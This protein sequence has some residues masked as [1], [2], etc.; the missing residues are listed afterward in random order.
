MAHG[1]FHRQRLAPMSVALVTGAARG[2][3]AATVR[4][5]GERGWSIVAF[6]RAEDDPALPYPLGT[7][8]Q[9]HAPTAPNVHVVAGD[10]RDDRAL[11]SAVAEAE[12][13]F[14]G[15]DAAIAIAGVIAGGL[16]LWQLPR[17]QERAVIDVNLGGVLAL[18]PAAI[19]VLLRRPAARSGRFLAVASA[20]ATSGLPMLAAY[21]ASKAA[22]TG[23]IRA[24]AVELGDSGVTAVAVSP[25]STQTSILDE[26]AR[27]YGLA[28]PQAFAHQQ[29]MHRLLPSAEIAEVLA[30]LAG[31]AQ[32][33]HD[34][35]DRVR[36]RRSVLVMTS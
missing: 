23:P 10:V 2:V 21:C 12:S 19:P 13:R 7:T 24:L 29:P 25:G 32:F 36:R 18:A 3:G 14:G 15:L 11:E 4:L 26:S 6:D 1:R 5:L 16:P 8:R 34:R 9:L 20:A 22:V 27:L 35:R 30:F 31:P 33:G 28:D 17:E